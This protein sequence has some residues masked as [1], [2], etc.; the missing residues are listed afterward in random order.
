MTLNVKEF[1]AKGDGTTDDRQAI[2][3]AIDAAAAAGGGTV[4]L[5][6]GE[7]RVSGGG[8]P[9]DGALELKDNVY[10]QGAGMGKTVI[11]MV[12]GW[13]QDV[14]GVVRSP[15]A[16]GTSN[17]GISDMTLDGNRDNI[18]AGVKVDGWFNGYAPGQNG[19]DRNVTI[20][21][22]EVRE[23][24]G[25]GF[26]PHEQTYNLAIRD[27][28]AHDNGLDGFVAD[29]QVNGIFENNVAYNNDRHGF[30]VVT[31]THD[32]VLRD[33]EAYGNGGNGVVVQRGSENLPS[34]DSILIDG[35]SYH[36]NALE[37]VMVKMSDNVTVQDA[38]IYGNGRTGV[39]V[40]GA[41]GT[42]ILDNTI[43]DNAQ[44]GPFPEVAV[45]GFDD[46]A[47]VSGKVYPT[48]NTVIDGNTIN[49]ST[50][51]TYGVE[52]RGPN[53]DYTTV[54]NNDI[55][56]VRSPGILA[57]A[58]STATTGPSGG[59]DPVAAA[60]PGAG[61]APMTQ[62]GL[63]ND[64]LAG[65][66]DNDIL[67]GAGGRDTMTGNGGSDVF[68]FTDKL[69]S[70]RNAST[71]VSSIDLITDFTPG[72]DRIDVSALGYTG[73]GAG[74]DG[75]TLT[76]SLSSDGTK[77]YIKDL[78]ADEAGNRF[79]IA[80]QGN[81]LTELSAADFIFAGAAIQSTPLTDTQSEE[82]PMD[83]KKLN[84]AG[85]SPADVP[86]AA[87][88]SSSPSVPMTQGSLF[89]DHLV[90]T[91]DNDTLTG[92]GG[93]DTMTGNGGSDVFRFNDKL[94]SYRNASTGV[95]SIDTITDFTP[96][97]DRIDVSAL[98]YTGLGAGNDGHTLTASLSADGSKTYIKDLVADESGN[99]FQVALEG[100]HLTQLTPS[101]FIFAQSAHE[102]AAAAPAE[103]GGEVATVPVE[104]LGDI[105]QLQHEAVS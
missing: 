17:F 25:Y 15:F 48:S 59:D 94:D 92:A 54:S 51:S 77:T 9:S 67:T 68:R 105:G 29:Y 28:V 100:N 49:G 21:R 24:S 30:N 7:Y 19:A 90:G 70:Y 81:H 41:E 71:G 87:A 45:Q 82:R 16:V 98:G 58:H 63:F 96:G 52:E 84:G 35:G 99:R 23:M 4:Y 89:N 60:E 3:A 62:G 11:K 26:D 55:T 69:D 1:G 64:H 65:G 102:P 46:T 22:V 8:E 33:N 91:A 53:T 27:S 10:L 34:P 44:S 13:N 93:R 80:L 104:M 31:S 5:P 6:A 66:A 50:N 32:F 103:G 78:V 72:T 2:Q 95:S 20:E 97:T 18:P 88:E 61:S 42:K 79:Q 47:G 40:L 73:L 39:R 75:S 86:V 56:E 43:K 36:D 37:G 38:D 12:D 57:G 14:T 74:N 83:D 101:D 85:Q 76:A